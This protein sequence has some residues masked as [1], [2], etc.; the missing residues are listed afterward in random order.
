MLGPC[1]Q[2]LRSTPGISC[3]R[4]SEVNLEEFFLFMASLG[5]TQLT[6]CE[7]SRGI[8]KPRKTTRMPRS[9]RYSSQTPSA[10]LLRNV[11]REIFEIC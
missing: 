4:A 10:V 11:E 7:A 8:D 9:D 6:A 5:F 3:I 2:N 1:T